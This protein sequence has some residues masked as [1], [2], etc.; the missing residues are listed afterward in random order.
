M[1]AKDKLLHA[2]ICFI[3]AIYS[4][5]VALTAAITKEYADSKAYG[6]K[7]SWGDIGADI[8]GIIIGRLLRGLLITLG[9]PY[10]NIQNVLNQIL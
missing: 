6:N 3:L 8:V 4:I 1:I 9:F 7:W 5:D 2:L 10:D